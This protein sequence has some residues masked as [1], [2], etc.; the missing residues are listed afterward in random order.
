MD[1]A[2]SG[3]KALQVPEFRQYVDVHFQRRKVHD[4]A[5]APAGA[6][7]QLDRLSN[8]RRAKGSHPLDLNLPGPSGNICVAGNHILAE[9]GPNPGDPNPRKI[10]REVQ[11]HHSIAAT[12]IL[13]ALALAGSLAAANFPDPPNFT[14]AAAGAKSETVV[15]AG[16]CF[17][18]M[19]GVFE[20]VKG[21][22][23][24]MVGYA[25]GQK[26]T[27]HYEMVSEGNTGHAESLEITFD[28]SQVSFGQLLKVYFQVAHDPTT[29]NRQHYDVGTQYRSSIFYA[30]EE[31]KK[32]AEEYIHALDSAHVYKNQIV[33]K[34]VPLE[35]FFPAEAYHQ[36]YMDRNPMDGYILNVDV[37]IFNAF[38]KTFPDLYRK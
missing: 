14:L 23:N 9:E 13:P 11:M 20:H 19:Q 21:V 12:L 22:T 32:T 16:G 31:Q 8:Q 34:V 35:G 26:K 36:H 28:P 17:W 6:K 7:G 1:P 30:T 33:T 38:K 15:L 18:G 4:F 25:G 29:L 2:S 5:P 24:T 10:D 27:A 3:G 37:P